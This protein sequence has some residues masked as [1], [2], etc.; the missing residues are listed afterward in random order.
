VW[1]VLFSEAGGGGAVFVVG[2][3][4][5]GVRSR[6]IG[7]IFCLAESVVCL[8]LLLRLDLIR[9]WREVG[10]PFSFD[11]AERIAWW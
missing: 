5:Q 10:G 9:E 6:S 1:T 7:G 8:L 11:I 3:F 2:G 4:I